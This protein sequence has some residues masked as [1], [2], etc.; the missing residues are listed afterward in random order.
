MFAAAQNPLLAQRVVER[1][2]QSDDLFDGLAVAATPQRI[3]GFIVEGNVE[4]RTE[5]EIEPEDAQQL[6]GNFPVAPNE[7][8]IVPVAQLLRIR[9]L[10]PDQPQARDAASFLVDRDDRL[11]FAE[12]AQIIDQLPELPRALN[13]AAKKNESARLDTTK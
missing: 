8:N 13:V 6:A 10:V 7:C 2:R 5:I 3:I 4:H 9:R 11:D 1:A 12:I